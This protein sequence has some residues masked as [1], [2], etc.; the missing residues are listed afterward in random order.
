MEKAMATAVIGTGNIGGAVARLLVNGEEPVVLASR[1]EDQASALAQE[2]GSLAKAS[3]IDEA[4]ADADAVVLAVWLDV[5]KDLVSQQAE[6]LD[7]KVVIDPSNPLTMDESGDMGRSLPDDQS[8]GAEIAALLPSGAH[9]VKA[10]GTLGAED[11]AT[12]AN[13]TPERAALLYASDDDQAEKVVER[14][15]G[16]AG[17]DPVKAGGVDAAIRIEIPGG[18][19]HQNGP[20]FNGKVPTAAEALAAIA[21][22]P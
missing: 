16:A 19:L 12:S 14:L 9:Y 6:R 17:F 13:R 7:G 20:R 1:D 5:E 4:I 18:D 22:A 8:A 10:F 15:I 2:L 11:L 3:T 21:E